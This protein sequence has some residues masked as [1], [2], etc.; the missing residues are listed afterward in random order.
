MPS[1]EWWDALI[2]KDKS[3]D[4]IGEDGTPPN[5]KNVTHLV[6]HP[7]QIE[8]PA[9]PSQPAA[10]PIMLTKKERKK[11]RTQRRKAEEKEK[12]EKIRLGLLEAPAP[13]VKKANFMRVLGME[14]VADPTKVEAIVNAQTAIRQ[15]DH[16]GANNARALTAE[17]KKEKLA[18][19]LKEDTSL[20][21]EVAVFR[22]NSL[23]DEKQKYKINV[24]AKQYNLTGCA[25]MT[26]SSLNVVVVEGGAKGVKKYK[27]L[28]MHRIKWSDEDADEDSDDED[29]NP[30]N[31]CV[32]VW[33]G[34]IQKRSF[35]AFEMKVC[36]KENF[37]RGYFNTFGVPQY[38]VRKST[39]ATA[40]EGRV[41]FLSL[42]ASPHARPHGARVRRSKKKSDRPALTFCWTALALVQLAGHVARG[43]RH[44]TEHEA[45]R[46]K[47]A[48]GACPHRTRLLDAGAG[49]GSVH[50]RRDT[51]GRFC[52]L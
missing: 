28:M 31:K 7:I 51:R 15:R 17:Q 22:I 48:S 34:Q 40:T 26:D 21:V 3:Y 41:V 5:L 30:P 29:G 27:R 1:V 19:K 39:G 2:L 14:A 10:L 20:L 32:L 36:R 11:L 52:G 42:L 18:N 43:Q 49:Q 38:W 44:R 37:A 46:L 25:V 50:L 4:E 23:K 35:E 45:A 47:D 33:E 8:P 24:N 6:Q 12:S 13:K 9:E 16:N